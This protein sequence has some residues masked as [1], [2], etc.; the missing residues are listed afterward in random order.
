MP[1]LQQIA[2]TYASQLFWL[3]LVFGILYF[4]IAKAMLPKVGRVIES[5]EAKIAGDLA[6]AQSAQNR[7]SEA[8]TAQASTL[9]KARDEAQG[10]VGE[11]T[12][13]MQQESAARLGALD[14]ELQSR[15]SEAEA[16]I[17]N[18]A[19]QASAE[20]D[21]VAAGAAA[22]IVARLTGQQA[23][24]EAPVAEPAAARA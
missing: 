2:E 1:Q 16:R 17:A 12:A 14:E 15:V 13:R 20:L 23:A 5:R 10:I 9:A 11:A 24:D 8:Q 19:V 21:K 4:G 7:A 22:D 6:E 18:A 3:L